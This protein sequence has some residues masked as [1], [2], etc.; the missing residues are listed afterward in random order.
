MIEPYMPEFGFDAFVRKEYYSN[1]SEREA[2]GV[3]L[4]SFEEYLDEN[5]EWLVKKYE[6]FL[7]IG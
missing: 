5:R 2:Y 7:S 1:L 4:I 6:H 3:A